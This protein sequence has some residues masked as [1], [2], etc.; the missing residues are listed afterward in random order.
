MI[1]RE[2]G[3]KGSCHPSLDLASSCS[4]PVLLI[5]LW[6]VCDDT[7][8]FGGESVGEWQKGSSERK[9]YGNNGIGLYCPQRLILSVHL[10]HLTHYCQPWLAVAIQT[11][12]IRD[13]NLAPLHAKGV[14][15]LWS[16]VLCGSSCPPVLGRGGAAS[17]SLYPMMWVWGLEV[18][19]CQAYCG[20]LEAQSS[21]SR[22][23]LGASRTRVPS[24]SANA[25]LK[26]QL[27]LET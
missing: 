25:S 21:T 4:S 27:Q 26:E 11:G 7:R 1:Y 15:C 17:A 23:L 24:Q 12:D 10:D 19:S 16:I 9:L 6:H 2:S 14:V 13:W 18:R 22:A 3:W 8:T 5:G 20:W